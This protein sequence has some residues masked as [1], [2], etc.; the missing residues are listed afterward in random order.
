MTTTMP[1]Q[2]QRGPTTAEYETVRKVWEAT[3]VLTVKDKVTSAWVKPQERCG[4]VAWESPYKYAP[5]YGQFYNPAAHD[6]SNRD[7]A[8][9]I[10]ASGTNG[11]IGASGA[12][13][14]GQDTFYVRS[15]EKEFVG[16]P[17]LPEGV[18]IG[19][20]E[21]WRRD[22]PL[23]LGGGDMRVVK[24]YQDISFEELNRVRA[25]ANEEVWVTE[26]HIKKADKEAA[27]R[28][29]HKLATQEDPIGEIAKAIAGA[30]AR[31]VAPS[32][33]VI[34]AA[35]KA[36]LEWDENTGQFVLKSAVATK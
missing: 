7:R 9:A 34:A 26:D 29:E 2:G 21:C 6:I 5:D 35:R 18:V 22:V 32:F 19:G 28:R 8:A 4:G 16:T 20:N 1:V 30:Q 15:V 10:G 17:K 3:G 11:V 14:F 33:E 36:G 31:P 13:G 12:S 27:K 24:W 25:W 23:D